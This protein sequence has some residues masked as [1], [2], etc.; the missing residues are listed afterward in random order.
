MNNIKIFTVS[1]Q[2]N[3]R[4]FTATKSIHGLN[5]KQE[6]ISDGVAYSYMNI[7]I[8]RVDFEFIEQ[9]Y[10]MLKMIKDNNVEL[11]GEINIK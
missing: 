6:I 11:L 2:N 7:D 9:V 8:L 4:L 1:V 5:I 3:D 10:F